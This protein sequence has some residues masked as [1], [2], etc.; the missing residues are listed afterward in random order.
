MISF[1]T[2]ATEKDYG[3]LK[4][5]LPNVLRAFGIYIQELVI[6]V[7]KLQEEGRIKQMHAN[8]DNI[9]S[10]AEA[11]YNLIK[12]DDRIRIID[13]DYQKVEQISQKWFNLDKVIRC[14]AGTPIFAFLYAIEMAQYPLV[15]RADCDVI[16]HNK[17]I[18]EKLLQEAQYYDLI[19]FPFLNDDI[20]P[21]ST[22]A[23]FINKDRIARIL[24]IDMARLDILRQ[25][26]RIFIGRNHYLAL[27]Q[28][29]ETNI[30]KN[31]LK[32]FTM[33]S[34]FGYTMHISKRSDFI[35]AD[36]DT[37]IVS[38]NNGIIPHKQLLTQHDFFKKYWL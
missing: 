25:I 32:S 4:L 30:K 27:E 15:I 14:Q 8:S 38:F 35:D 13:L 16:F 7:D 26:H 3:R 20:I 36:I 1:V 12:I 31:V 29:I 23:F 5:F 24:P 11:I 34:E 22:R 21:F 18:V 6:V 10:N 17:K 37:I 28:I 33:S 19:Q 2:N 9:N